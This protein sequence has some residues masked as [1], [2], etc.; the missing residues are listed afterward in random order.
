MA[1]M[2]GAAEPVTAGQPATGRWPHA[3]AVFATGA[4]L[5]VCS[6]VLVSPDIV[7]TA[8]HCLEAELEVVVGTL[9]TTYATRVTVVQ[10]QAHPSEAFDVAWLR[11]EAAVD[12]AVAPVGTECLLETVLVDGTVAVIAGYGTTDA[13]GE[14]ATTLQH[15][16]A[17]AI[18]DAGCAGSAWGCRAGAQP[19]GELVA[20]ASGP[21]DACYGDSGAP[22]YVRSQAG[23]VLVGVASRSIDD[24]E[25]PCGQGS[26]YV[27]VD[28]VMPWLEEAGVVPA[29]LDCTGVAD[30]P[31][32]QV[33][34]C[35]HG[36]AGLTAWW[37]ALLVS[38]RRATRRDR[39][40]SAACPVPSAQ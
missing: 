19:D 23:D 3:A 32:A 34:G 27:R 4:E 37:L 6:G 38:C 2:A 39:S 31:D 17:V 20:G 21:E 33:E 7:L 29:T 8:A 13:W 25:V 5:P 10:G 24:V 16:A 9:D 14:D 1:A 26:I 18:D 28:A 35:V 12:T 22:L 36:P 40:T 15:E 30:E 11:L